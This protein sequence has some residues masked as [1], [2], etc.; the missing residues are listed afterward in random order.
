MTAIKT[1]KDRADAMKRVANRKLP[2]EQVITNYKK[3][4]S[5]PQNALSHKWYYLIS[6]ATKEDTPGGIK[7]FCKLNFGVPILRANNEAFR[8]DY[9]RIVKPLPYETKVNIMSIEGWFPVTS[10][11]NVEHLS[12]YLQAMQAHYA[13]RVQLLFPDEIPMEAYS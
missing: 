3:D 11:M 12:E 13:D 2:F 6:R 10:L 5:L 8:A 9:D 1:E 7:G 4:R